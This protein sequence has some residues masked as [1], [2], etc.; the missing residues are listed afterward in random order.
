MPKQE[1]FFLYTLRNNQ[2]M[3]SEVR[4]RMGKDVTG[5][6]EKL[7]LSHWYKYLLYVSGI[8]LILVVVFGSQIPQA[9]LISF[10]LWT[11]GLS[12]FVWIMDDIFYV[13]ANYYFEK[14]YS[15]EIPDEVTAIIWAKHLIHVLFFF[16]WV[17]VTVRSF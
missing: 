8:I 14:A 7:S 9:N 6:L 16:L 10:C 12:L 1:L 2:K 17:I 13:A 11:M 4:R 3:K 5:F 15:H